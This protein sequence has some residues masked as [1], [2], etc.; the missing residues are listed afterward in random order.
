LCLGGSRQYQAETGYQRERKSFSCV[1]FHKY[2]MLEGLI[3][4]L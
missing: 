4:L 1:C 2:R 3:Y